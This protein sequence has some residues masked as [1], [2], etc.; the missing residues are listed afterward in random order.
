MHAA[1]EGDSGAEVLE[2]YETLRG[3]FELL[4]FAIEAFS[5]GVGDSLAEVAD[6]PRPMLPE[7]LR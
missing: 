6:D 1:E 2:V 5:H 7:P 4:D 3:V